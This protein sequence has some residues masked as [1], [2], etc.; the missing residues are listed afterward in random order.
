MQ[1]LKGHSPDLMSASSD[2]ISYRRE[3]V[4]DFDEPRSSPYEDIKEPFQ[5]TAVPC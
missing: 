5:Q 3:R 2:S 4:I 1:K